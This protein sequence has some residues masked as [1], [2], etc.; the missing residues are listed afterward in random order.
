MAPR[1]TR[2]P[3][4]KHILDRAPKLSALVVGDVCLDRWCRY[5][6]RLGEPSRETGIPRTAVTST[7]VT[8]GA[9]GTVAN[10]LSA[11]G[12]GRVSVLG[13]IGQDGHGFELRRALRQRRIDSDL[14]VE[15][16][17]VQT[18]TYTKLINTQTGRED[19]PR[20]DF[21]NA[22]N[23]PEPAV[24]AVLDRLQTVFDLFDIVIVCDQ[25]ES[26]CGGVIN[27]AVRELLHELAPV[28]P[29]KIILVDS[30]THIGEFRS[31]IAK[32]NHIEAGRAA[33]ELFGRADYSALR[34]HMQSPLL[35]RHPR[36][37]RRL[38]GHAGGGTL[39]AD[40]G[41][42]KSRGHMR[43]GR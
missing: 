6:P 11:L 14:L 25:A 13:V 4:V 40:R 16:P 8:P 31:V 43:R 35:H 24:R 22:A 2:R 29:D 42:R 9:A 33:N 5:D 7:E 36:P 19:Q 26:G 30:R 39:G 10:N 1:P 28:Y 27:Q 32:P 12:V 34:T 23:L 41:G 15:S 38:A 37:R 18:F 20:I 17:D 3:Q 21:V